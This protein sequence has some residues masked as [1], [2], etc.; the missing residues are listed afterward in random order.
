MTLANFEASKLGKYDDA[1]LPAVDDMFAEFT[2][3][4]VP[5]YR[6]LDGYRITYDPATIEAL[7]P[8]RLATAVAVKSLNVTSTDEIRTTY[9]NREAIGG[10]GDDILVPANM[11]PIGR[12]KD[13]SD[14]AD[15][16]VQAAKK[17]IVEEE[18]VAEPEGNTLLEEVED[19]TDA[20]KFI[21]V[22]QRILK[23][24]DEEALARAVQYGMF[25]DEEECMQYL[26]KHLKLDAPAAL[27][28]AIQL[29][30]FKLDE[31]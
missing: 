14:A 9:L 17:P 23:L 21:N 8:R 2:R 27:A 20:E 3:L 10:P 28:K 5:R 30:V 24:S 7:E 26:S 22:S 12:D 18:E 15:G 13:T 6:D 19:E 29:G 1:I 4:L 16:G 31:Q 25:K 11:L